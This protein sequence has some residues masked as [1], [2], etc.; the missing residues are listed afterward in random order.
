MFLFS[1]SSQMLVL[2]FCSQPNFGRSI[3]GRHHSIED[4]EEPQVFTGVE[5][6][7]IWPEPDMMGVGAE[8]VFRAPPVPRRR[9]VLPRDAIHVLIVVVG[10][11]VIAGLAGYWLS[12]SVHPSASTILLFLLGLG[13][14]GYAISWLL[15]SGLMPKSTKDRDGRRRHP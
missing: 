1:L 12:A 13:V 9:P 4:S 6:T 15:G 5:D 8:H 10:G 2:Y 11:G 14:V 3:M 7:E